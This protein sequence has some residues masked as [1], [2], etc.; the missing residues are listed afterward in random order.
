MEIL[1][2]EEY[3]RHIRY[4]RRYSIHTLI[5]YRTDLEQFKLFCG[6]NLLDVNRK[7]V[8]AF[9]IN[10]KIDGYSPRTINRKLEVLRSFYRY[11]RRH[12]EYKSF[13]CAS[14]K[15][16]RFIKKRVK[17]LSKD[18][19]KTAIENIRP[20]KDKILFRNKLLVELLY[21]TGCRANEIIN[22][23][24]GDVDISRK[25]V[26]VT[27][28]GKIERIIPIRIKL[29]KMIQKHL[30][31]SCVA[32]QDQ[33]V[34]ITHHGKKMY[35]MYLWRLLRKYFNG[36]NQASAH[37]LRHSFATHLYHNR[38]PID[39]VRDLLGH[40]SIKSTRTYLH[41]ENSWLKSIYDKSHPRQ[42]IDSREPSKP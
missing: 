20:G 28:K 21:Q 10:L 4:V 17:Y 12:T 14:I 22:L 40:K 3:L 23:K 29:C 13:P 27:G 15:K 9:L 36:E 31:L 18:V 38:A 35:P 41:V 26:L 25:Q 2:I 11:Y 16:H 19:L 33:F 24:V 32:H 6:K 5:A 8:R 30:R 34:F 39:S 7:D 42:V 37:T 1:E